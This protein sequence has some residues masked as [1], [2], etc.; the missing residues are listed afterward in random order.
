M[1]GFSKRLISLCVSAEVGAALSR[2]AGKQGI[3]R[4]DL[5]RRIV[6]SCPELINEVV[7]CCRGTDL[8]AP[9][10][11]PDRAPPAP[12]AAPCET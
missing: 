2:M 8:P 7:G 10:A 1:K 3:H 12:S 4:N 11:L 9:A 6:E 5:I